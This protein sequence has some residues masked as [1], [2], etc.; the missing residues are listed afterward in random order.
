MERLVEF[1][2]DQGFT[3]LMTWRRHGAGDG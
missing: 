1:S 2:L 3:V